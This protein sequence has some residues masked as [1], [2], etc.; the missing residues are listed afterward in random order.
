[1]CR[2]SILFKLS[3][4]QWFGKTEM[5]FLNLLSHLLFIAPLQSSLV[6]HNNFVMLFLGAASFWSLVHGSN[7]SA[8][9]C[10]ASFSFD[11]MAP[12]PFTWL[13]CRSLGFCLRMLHILK[14]LQL[15]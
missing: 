1:M 13:Y 9:H 5:E 15:L 12:T 8:I 11:C 14:L 10:N 3:F 4:F 6:E 2:D 7:F